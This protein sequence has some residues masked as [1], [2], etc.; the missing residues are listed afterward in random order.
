LL[1]ELSRKL[2]T[3]SKQWNEI[4]GTA[5]LAP[6]DRWIASQHPNPPLLRQS[7]IDGADLIQQ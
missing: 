3:A 2:I 5:D 4:I 6:V 1:H 7:L